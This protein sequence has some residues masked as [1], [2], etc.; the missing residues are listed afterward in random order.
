M[1]T[2]VVYLRVDL[3]PNLPSQ[4]LLFRG[5]VPYFNPASHMAPMSWGGTSGWKLCV[6]ANICPPP[7]ASLPK[8]AYDIF[9]G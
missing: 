5:Y 1:C 2:I 3:G 9:D 8:L 6:G 7:G 4:H